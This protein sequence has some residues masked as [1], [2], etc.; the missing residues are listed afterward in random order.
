MSDHYQ[1]DPLRSVRIPD[2]IWQA[3]QAAAAERGESVSEVIRRA[4]RRYAQ[5]GRTAPKPSSPSW[6]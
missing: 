1:R 4:L 6:R 2:D 3:A 5:T